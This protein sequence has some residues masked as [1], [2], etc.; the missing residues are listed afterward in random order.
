[1]GNMVRMVSAPVLKREMSRGMLMVGDIVP[2]KGL[3][4]V[5]SEA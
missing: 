5:N 1:M 3:I 4:V 2:V